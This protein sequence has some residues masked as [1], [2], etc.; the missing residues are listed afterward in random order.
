MK[1]LVIDGHPYEKSFCRAVSATYEEGAKSAGHNVTLLSL[2]D[3]QFE[4]S[5]KGGY[6]VIQ[7]LEPDL[8]KAQ[9][10]IKEADH[11]V[12]VTPIW[13]GAPPALLKG[14][15]DR[16]FLPGFA[17]KY[18]T[19]SLWW[20]KYLTGK[21]GHVIA[22][23]DAPGWYMRFIRGDSAVKLI[24]EST[25]QFTGVNPVKVTRLGNIKRLSEDQRKKVLVRIQKLAQSLS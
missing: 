11:I 23:S 12:I 19:D 14:F 15:M 4:L 21:S 18:R 20:D 3:L 13:W 8:L 7:E 10:L 24:R 1:V 6:K 2:R 25:L 17:F 9:S 5:L 22:T 16:T